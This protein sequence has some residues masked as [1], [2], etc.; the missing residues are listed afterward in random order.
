MNININIY[1]KKYLI[2]IYNNKNII[3]INYNLN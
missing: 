1:L 3:I 2:T